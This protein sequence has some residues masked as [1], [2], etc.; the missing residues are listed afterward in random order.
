MSKPLVSDTSLSPLVRHPNPSIARFHLSLAAILFT[1]AKGTKRALDVIGASFLLVLSVPIFIAVAALVAIDGGPIFFFHRRVGR[2]GETFGCIKFRTMILGAEECL[3][4]YLS[5]HPEAQM[6]WA[7]ERK[8]SF[9]P[10]VTAIG[11]FLRLSSLD[12]LPQLLNVLKGEMSLVGPRPVTQGELVH[13]G[14]AT[15]LYKSVRPG[16]TGLWQVSGRN[17]LAYELR[18]RLDEQY[19]KNWSFVADLRILLRTPAV[20]VSRRGAR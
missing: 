7:K 10:R 16:I 8:L 5:Y 2:K 19:V 11:R 6:E 18:V 1:F 14:F 15:P 20:V 12:E 3:D 17:E 13:Y 4:E 9:D